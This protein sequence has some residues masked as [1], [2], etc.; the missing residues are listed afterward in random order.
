M[1]TSKPGHVHGGRGSFG[2]EADPRAL[3][4]QGPACW[5]LAHPLNSEPPAQPPTVAPRSILLPPTRGSL[6]GPVSFPELPGLGLRDVPP[7]V[8]LQ[9]GPTEKET[10]RGGGQDGAGAGGQPLPTSF[11]WPL[12][13]SR[14]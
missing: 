14:S 5:A 11:H 9:G 8:H 1:L 2:L 10:L 12:D 13:P 7:V 6:G 4:L 3:G